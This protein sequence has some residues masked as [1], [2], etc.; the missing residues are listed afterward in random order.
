MDKLTVLLILIVTVIVA[1]KFFEKKSFT[2]RNQLPYQQTY[3][4]MNKTMSYQVLGEGQSVILLHGSMTS[5]PWNGFEAK[6]AKEYKVFVPD[7][8]GFGA[9]D[10]I[11]G[12]IHNTDLFSRALCEFIKQ[13]NLQEASIISLSLGTDVSAKAAAAGC[14]G[15]PL[16]FVG[17]PSQVSG[18][19]S[20]LLQIIPLPIKHIIV[21]TYWGKD[22]LL[23]PALDNNIGNKTKKDNSKFISELETSDVRAIADVNYFREIN[24]E[25]PEIIKQLK[26][27]VVFIYGVNDTQKNHVAYLTDKIIEIRDSGHNVFE[28]QP[29]KLIEQ[30]KEILHE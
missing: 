18:L 15:G 10:A 2:K 29:E 8:P 19:F 1:V 6:L 20:R 23:I 27:K 4:F 25:F 3:Q 7:L 28:G 5:I 14:A 16:I 21:G 24:Q 13:Q 12:Q 30:I 26:N 11:D 17:S 9:S 22:K